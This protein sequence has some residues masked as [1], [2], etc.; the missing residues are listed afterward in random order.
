MTNNPFNLAG[1]PAETPPVPTTLESNPFNLFGLPSISGH[2]ATTPLGTAYNTVVGLPEAAG[3]VLK[4]TGQALARD[5]FGVGMSLGN[6]INKMLGRDIAT[7]YTPSDNI[8]KAILGEPTND[9]A[10][11]V[12]QAED[13]IKNNPI[14]KKFGLDKAAAPLAF[15]GVIGSVGLDFTPM[16][17]EDKVIGQLLK[18]GTSDGVLKIL[19]NLNIPAKIAT[20]YAPKFAEAN[21]PKEVTGLMSLMK[22][23]VGAENVAKETDLLAKNVSGAGTPPPA[24]PSAAVGN[25]PLE[26]PI[27]SF[28]KALQEAK[29][30]RSAQEALYTETRAQRFA[31]MQTA[32]QGK[33]G[34]EAFSAAK[35][36][37]AGEMPKVQF[38]SLANKMSQDQIDSIFNT[39]RD[40]P[41]LTDGERL[42]GWNGLQ[43]MFGKAGGTVPTEGEI[44]ILSRVF[45]QDTI[46]A[47]L[48]N[49]PALTKIGDGIV[50]ALNV[51][52]AIMSSADLSAPFRQ[53]IFVAGRKE[54]RQAFGQMLK[55]FESENAFRASQEEIFKRPTYPIM[56]D[57]KLAIMNNSAVLTDREE[58]FVAANLAEKIPIAGRGIRASDRAYTG[59]LNKVRADIFD[60]LYSK[61]VAQKYPITDKFVA[62][63]GKYINAATGRG[64][65]KFLARTTDTL[66][67]LMFSPRLMFS[68]L[69]LL[70]PFFYIKLDPF[71]RREAL[72][73]LLR[74]TAMQGTFLSLAAAAGATVGLNPTSAD[75]G[76][77]K[78]GNTRIDTMGGF[79]QYIR[80]GAQL[81]SGKITS[82]TTGKVLTLGEGYKPLTRLD[83]LERFFQGKENPVA[84]FVTDWLQGEDLVGNKFKVGPEIINR[85]TP[86]ITQ[87]MF[88]VFKDGG[89]VK[90]L[91]VTAAGI[92]GF[93]T[94]TYTQTTKQGMTNPFNI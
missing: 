31:K 44:K 85:V 71:V 10:T 20:E 9:L 63:L 87:D 17:S 13:A 24:P 57:A 53:G 16:G 33:S 6:V 22:N 42:T 1:T 66:S 80:L 26:D 2:A 37:M 35:G 18:E 92:F 48:D 39:V 58:K 28:T 91:G 76:K 72:K 88:D 27:A 60:D 68:R 86:M 43:K 41:L 83:I 19:S 3:K 14:A 74:F 75:F 54:F 70:N 30:I 5:F 36:A 51:P 89:F 77:I 4:G 61:A 21:T 47:M 78:I 40:S 46:K 49:R 82:S 56:K 34:E 8:S 55:D 59:F 94:Q 45:P 52:R 84:S 93:G 29:P 62:D 11:R 50:Q 69:N 25:V 90:G 15:G 79:Q 67:K 65:I 12:V 23:S 81:L 7:Q 64:D 73:D 38:E 32:I